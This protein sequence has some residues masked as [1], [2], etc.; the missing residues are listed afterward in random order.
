MPGAEHHRMQGTE[1]LM[2]DADSGNN[3]ER[4]RTV[5]KG[6]I[7]S[8]WKAHQLLVSITTGYYG[9]RSVPV[10][11]YIKEDNLENYPIKTTWRF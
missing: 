7:Y 9:L 6:F 1:G 4:A 3:L 5:A 2:S 8:F 11:H 10:I